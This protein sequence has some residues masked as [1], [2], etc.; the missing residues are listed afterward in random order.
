MPFSTR[1]IIVSSDIVSSK[2]NTLE[3]NSLH[4]ISE[5]AA[6]SPVANNAELIAPIEVPEKTPIWLHSPSSSKALQTPTSYA[7]FAPPPESTNPIVYCLFSIS[8]HSS[9]LKEELSE[10]IFETRITPAPIKA[11][12]IAN[13]C[14]NNCPLCRPITLPCYFDN[15][16]TRRPFKSSRNFL[17]SESSFHSSGRTTSCNSLRK[18]SETGSGT[19]NDASSRNKRISQAKSTAD[20][21]GGVSSPNCRAIAQ[22]CVVSSTCSAKQ[23]LIAVCIDLHPTA[24]LNISPMDNNCTHLFFIAH[25]ILYDQDL[26]P[27]NGFQ[28]GLPCF[29]RANFLLRQYRL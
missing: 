12:T 24:P 1:E 8:S 9:A 13:T 3:I 18:D 29:Q 27:T 15:T 16:S 14:D 20:R 11:H 19:R 2:E 28:K 10:R 21:P 22:R 25:L 26:L 5:F 6:V 17:F 4:M 7:P 23:G